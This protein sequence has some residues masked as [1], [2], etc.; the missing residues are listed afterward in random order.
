[1]TA[2]LQL[3]LDEVD[4]IAYAS[5]AQPVCSFY[6]DDSIDSDL[7]VERARAIV[8]RVNVHE[9]MLKALEAAESAI[10][11]AAEIMH[12]ED[13][14]PVTFLESREIEIA[15]G[16][17]S[18]SGLRFKKLSAMAALLSLQERKDTGHDPPFP[19]QHRPCRLHPVPAG[20]AFGK[21]RFHPDRPALSRVL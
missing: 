15:H 14:L 3:Q 18:P 13:D 1:M 8:H 11:E 9:Q 16:T 20:P 12:Y 6:Y 4:M 17:S 21:R 7:P 5:E 19:Q 2:P 10:S